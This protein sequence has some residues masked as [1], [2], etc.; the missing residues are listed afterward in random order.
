MSTRPLPDKFARAQY[1]DMTDDEKLSAPAFESM[2][3]GVEI[4]SSGVTFGAG[5]ASSTDYETF[6]YDPIEEAMVPGD[7]YTVGADVL[8]ALADIGSLRKR[9]RFG[10]P[11]REANVAWS[12]YVVASTDD[13]SEAAVPGVP[14][15]GARTYS[16]AVAAMRAHTA[17]H[18]E[19]R[20][21]LQLVVTNA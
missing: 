13:L 14:A 7:T 16:E 2:P 12:R 6:I 5:V 19:Q 10:G 1:F 9:A 17:A 15:G 18:P 8:G 11:K 21:K 3:A 20:S 4:G